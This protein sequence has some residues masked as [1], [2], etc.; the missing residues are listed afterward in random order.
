MTNKSAIVLGATGLIGS[1]LLKQLLADESYGK[2]TVLVRRPL[3]IDDPKFEQHVVDFADLSSIA[4]LMK[5]DDVF[6][7]LGTTHKKAGSKEAFYA[8]DF[9]LVHELA[10]LAKA[11]DC[12]HSLMVSSIGANPKA[13]SS[14]MKTK[15]EIEQAIADLNFPRTSIFRPSLLLG[16][17]KEYRVGEGLSEAFMRPLAPL[18]L[19]PLKRY[20]PIAAAQVA[21]GMIATAHLKGQGLEVYQSDQIAG[22]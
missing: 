20:R 1:H 2:V 12:E 14:Y 18:M 15:G 4:P 6:C 7:C 11:G 17:R 22:M 8:V 10:K 5:A 19:G 21:K 3:E 9:T 13:S 16:E